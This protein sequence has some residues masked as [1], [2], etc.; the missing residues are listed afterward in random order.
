M[1]V[2]AD[3]IEYENA[4]DFNT[5]SL[6]NN[7]CFYISYRTLFV[8]ARVLLNADA[9]SIVMAVAAAAVKST[10]IMECIVYQLYTKLQSML[11]F[12]FIQ[13]HTLRYL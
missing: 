1:S 8:V 7:V 10:L 5:N 6:E 3:T 9:D 12:Y 11:F 4:M 2:C 13:W